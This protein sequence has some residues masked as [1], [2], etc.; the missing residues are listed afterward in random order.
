MIKILL[1]GVLLLAACCWGSFSFSEVINGSTDNAVKDSLKWQMRYVLPPEAGLT[2]EGIFHKYTITKDA[3]KNSTVSIINKHIDGNSNIYEYSDN[4]DGIAGNTKVKYDPIA[5]TLGTLFGD[6]EIK[7]QGDGT[8]SDVVVHYQYKFDTCFNPLT[9]PE[10][11]EF[12]SAMLKYLL[13]NNLINNNP[14]IDDPFYN[15][16][17]QFS[18][19]QKAELKEEEPPKENE[20][21]EAEDELSIEEILSITNTAEGLVNIEQ[22]VAM[23]KNLV[24]ANKLDAYS[25]MKIDGGTFEETI[26]LK[27]GVLHD[28]NRAFKNLSTDEVHNKMVRSQYNLD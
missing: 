6:G 2:V 3:A 16:W 1:K 25:K 19:E 11:P 22:Q 5:S 7:V 24:G 15:Q 12:E 10:C 26:T 4:W 27:D 13:D 20:E 23:L 21:E 18:L 17:V 14:T 8:L 9:D 28:N